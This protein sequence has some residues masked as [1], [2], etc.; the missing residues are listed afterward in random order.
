MVGTKGRVLGTAKFPKTA[1]CLSSVH[2]AIPASWQSMA[3]NSIVGAL[4]TL[5]AAL[6]EL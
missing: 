5:Y 3:V 6:R 4:T 2:V 1:L